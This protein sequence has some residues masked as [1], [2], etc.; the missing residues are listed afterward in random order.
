MKFPPF[1]LGTMYYGTRVDRDTSFRMLDMYI[2]RGFDL[3]D[4]ANNYAF[5]ISG[6]QG[7]ESE[8]L[9][10][11]WLRSRSG[12]TAKIATKIGARPTVPGGSIKQIMGLSPDAVR[13]QFRECLE[14][15]GVGSVDLLYAHI[16]DQS[17]PLAE[18]LGALNDLIQD[19][20][21]A[22]IGLS[23][24][25]YPRLKHALAT[26]SDLNIAPISA[27]QLRYSALPPAPNGD[28]GVHVWADDLVRTTLAD[29]EIPLVAYSPLIEG[30]LGGLNRSLPAAF[31]SEDN[32]RRRRELAEEAAHQG[33]TLSQYCLRWLTDQGIT[34]IVGARTPEQLMEAL[35]AF[36]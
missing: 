20:S 6:T 26:I 21:T 24:F 31:D 12:R 30:G 17:V 4:T 16:D 5:W 22:S 29:Y 32:L 36:D 19:G 18:S 23:N 25:V 2:D 1:I 7:G 8:L 28:L 9:I 15:L 13:S 35:E 14:R 33:F 10:G 27:L 34:P 3:I 11:E